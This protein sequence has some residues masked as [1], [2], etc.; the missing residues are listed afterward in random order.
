[1]W[2]RSSCEKLVSIAERPVRRQFF[3][4]LA[5]ERAL[6]RVAVKVA[7]QKIV[8][9]HQQLGRA[10]LPVERIGR[11]LVFDRGRRLELAHGVGGHG[12]ELGQPGFAPPSEGHPALVQPVDLARQLAADLVGK[13]LLAMLAE[14]ERRPE[15][16][17]EPQTLEVERLAD[18]GDEGSHV[19]AIGGVG[20]EHAV[21]APFAL[22][23]AVVG[24]HP[25]LGMLVGAPA[26]EDQAGVDHHGDVVLVAAL[27]HFAQDVAP[28]EPAM[29]LADLGRIVEQPD[30]RMTVGHDALG[31]GFQEHLDVAIGVELR[32][33][34]LIPI[35]DVHVDDRAAVGGL[36]PA[37]IA[38]EHGGLCGAARKE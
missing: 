26:I 9:G 12:G 27:D 36:V 20:A 1:M 25:P 32:E 30:V 16:H 35:G 13:S 11:R 33:E 31:P 6:Q 15:G 23:L 2:S 22:R 21:A 17:V 3:Q 19:L 10:K 28:L 37:G 29:L 24:D 7:L 14:A 18:L 34:L 8:L 4:H 5:D 38:D